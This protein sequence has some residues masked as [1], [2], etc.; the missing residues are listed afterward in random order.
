MKKHSVLIIE[1]N[2]L[3]QEIL[4]DILGN[5]YN[6]FTAENGQ[7]GLSMLREHAA[8]VDV[9]L[10][11]I[12][13]PVMNGYEVLEE[14]RKDEQIR[15]IPIIVT[16]GNDTMEE[17]E[18]CL[19]LQA[20]DFVKKPYNPLIVRLRIE[21]LIRMRDYASTLGK[22]ER[23]K[24]TGVYTRNAFMHYAQK[25]I[26]RQPEIDYTLSMTDIRGF[27]RLVDHYG[28]SAYE[29]LRKEIGIMRSLYGNNII[30]GSYNIDQL[31]F[32]HPTDQ[33]EYSDDE[34]EKYYE[35]NMLRLSEELNVTI[36]AG[37][38]EH[39]DTSIELTEHV[40]H[41]YAALNEAK[42]IY[43][44]HS[45]IVRKDL[46]DKLQRN[47]RIEELM[48]EALNSGQ[49]QVYYQP[50]HDATTEKLVGAEALLR[51]ISPEL[52]FVSPGEFIPVFEQNGF[53]FEADA[54]VWRETCRNQRLWMDKGLKVVPISVNASRKDFAQEDLDARIVSPVHDNHL[55]ADLMHIEV[56]ES[57]FSNL[58][59]SAIELLQHFRSRGIQV[60][61]D[62]F[63][64]GYSSLNSL[65]ELPIDIVKFDMSFVR[66]LN[67]PRKQVVMKRCVDMLKDLN[68]HSVA[69]GVE[70][71]ETR[72][73]IANMGIDAIQGYYYS[74]PLPAD[75]FEE[76]L[77]RFQ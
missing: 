40:T 57:L 44:Q 6:L 34:K 51:W 30:I 31:I 43:N 70:D 62:D 24:Q 37:V 13:M 29:I 74:K 73:K 4:T 67:D 20:A 15:H 49:L 50:K 35:I 10:L 45:R 59:D 11:D 32:L 17:E 22:V 19:M 46:L 55:S 66:K 18:R 33:Q 63:G 25:K 69:E 60:E 26:N 36:K 72:L 61:L 76:Y 52:G 28:S 56:T 39:L 16:T 1:D 54:F 3:N 48:E 27:K 21:S 9:V 14:A 47:A 65:S 5:E 23:D 75:Q 7:I 64:T 12:Q 38:Y 8:E 2:E 58:S 53:V 71:A 41:V 68:L 42:K 77:A